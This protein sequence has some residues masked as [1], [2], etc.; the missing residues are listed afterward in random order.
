MNAAA[1]EVSRRLLRELLV[2]N[3]AAAGRELRGA[4]AM[5]ELAVEQQN[6]GLSDDTEGRL[7]DE[8]TEIV[9]QVEE[10]LDELDPGGRR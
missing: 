7:Q 2:Q 6:S 10:M 9:G 5:L 3:L 4:N 1:L 8:L